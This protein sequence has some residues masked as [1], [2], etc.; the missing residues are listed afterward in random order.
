MTREHK[1][2]YTTPA[3]ELAYE[4]L[5]RYPG[6]PIRTLAHY[7]I[8]NHG[9]LYD[10]DFEKARE[11]LRYYAGSDG[12]A[13]RQH[14][15]RSGRLVPRVAMP[16][17]VASVREPYRLEPGV[18]GIMSDVHCPFHDEEA[19]QAAVKFLHDTKVTGIL[20][21]GDFQDCEAVS[22]WKP[23]RKRDFVQEVE[24]TLDL[25]DWLRGEFPRAQVVF[26]PANH[27]ARLDAYYRT[28]APQL[29]DLPTASLEVILGLEQRKIEYLDRKQ[30]VMAG[31]LPIL[32]GDEIR[33]TYNPVNVAR[34]LGLKWK[35]IAACGH[36]H[37]SS[38]DDSTTGRGELWTTWTFGCL[39]DLHPDYNPFANGWTHGV[40]V[41]SVEKDGE[42][43]MHNHRIWQGGILS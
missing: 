21:N 1:G 8:A 39:C 19:L 42:F 13:K 29:A 38:Q 41:V 5:R 14:A 37:R 18:W 31:K 20:L 11:R 33:M 34:L 36:F 3:S 6:V 24:L 35:G 17:S 28:Y 43:Q 4:T 10:G 26:R 2:R 32:H 25:L 27:E 16:K 9:P 30:I 12:S 7:L 22:Y 15:Q 40:A 23:T